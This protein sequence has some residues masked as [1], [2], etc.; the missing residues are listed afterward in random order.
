MADHVVI[1]I[2]DIYGEGAC[3]SV[4]ARVQSVADLEGKL[5]VVEG[6][7]DL[8]YLGIW[9]S[10]VHGAGKDGVIEAASQVAVESLLEQIDIR[11]ESYAQ[12][13]C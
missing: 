10:R 4:G 13:P 11:W 8:D 7:R 3:G 5:E 2:V 1:E 6:V 9:R 12:V